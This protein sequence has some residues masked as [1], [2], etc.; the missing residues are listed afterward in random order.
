MVLQRWLW[1]CERAPHCP[2]SPCWKTHKHF[3]ICALNW[4]MGRAAGMLRGS[5]WGRWPSWVSGNIFLLFV[6][7]HKDLKLDDEIESRSPNI[8][9]FSKPVMVGRKRICIKLESA[10]KELGCFILCLKP[11]Q[12]SGEWSH[13]HMHT[14]TQSSTFLSNSVVAWPPHMKDHVCAEGASPRESYAFGDCKGE[15]HWYIAGRPK[16]LQKQK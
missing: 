3:V 11:K 13:I 14:Q 16:R 15:N 12:A 5:K 6:I 9:P 10:R 7:F 8:M 2:L 1:C 4:P